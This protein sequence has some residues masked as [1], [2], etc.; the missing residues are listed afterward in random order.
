MNNKWA[1]IADKVKELKTDND[2]IHKYRPW[3]DES[4]GALTIWAKLAAALPEVGTVTVK[5][6]EIH[7]LSSITAHGTAQSILDFNVMREKLAKT[8]GVTDLHADT[9]GQA[10]QIQYNLTYQ[11]TPGVGEETTNG[12]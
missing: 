4:F 6:F 8:P 10:P 11:W 12:N 7:D 2:N 5:T 3:F 1:A 9:A